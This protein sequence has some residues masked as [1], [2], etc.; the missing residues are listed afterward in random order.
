MKVKQRINIEE[1]GRRLLSPDVLDGHDIRLTEE[2][3][4]VIDYC[5]DIFLE[6]LLAQSHRKEKKEY[7]YLYN[8]FL[9]DMEGRIIVD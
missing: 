9:E 8:N 1:L 3:A 4:K 5:M 6:E 7:A 2:T